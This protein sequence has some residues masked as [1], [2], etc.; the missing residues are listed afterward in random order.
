MTAPMETYIQNLRN[1]EAIANGSA[2]D[3]E[4]QHRKG[5]LTARER[6]DA[7]FEP[8]TFTEIDTLVLPRFEVYLGGK[9]AVMEMA[10]SPA[11]A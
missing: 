5:R 7:L 3:A 9:P 2:K 6:V 1:R 8:G 11:L 4:T 10:S